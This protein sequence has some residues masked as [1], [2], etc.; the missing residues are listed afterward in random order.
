MITALANILLWPFAAKSLRDEIVGD[1]LE[2]RLPPC[3]MLGQALR[4][5]PPLALALFR[6]PGFL[7]CLLLAL[8]AGP[9]TIVWMDRLWALVYSAI[10]LKE[11]LIRAPLAWIVN[12]WVITA[13]SLLTGVALRG[14]PG[15]SRRFAFWTGLLIAACIA[16]ILPMLPVGA[17]LGIRIQ[18]LLIPCPFTLLGTEPSRRRSEQ[19]SA[20]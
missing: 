10:P 6:S 20:S 1:L 17:P 19:E 15:E 3:E 12:V 18:L 7:Q 8:L 9:L 16:L 14:K 2:L 4:S 5:V 11:D 13:T